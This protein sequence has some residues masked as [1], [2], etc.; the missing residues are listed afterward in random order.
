V[1]EAVLVY[2]VGTGGKVLWGHNV[3]IWQEVVES[4]VTQIHMGMS[5]CG[6]CFMLSIDFF[7]LLEFWVEMG[8]SGG[9]SQFNSFAN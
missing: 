7:M 8:D 4:E 3:L 2:Q 5:G 6:F 9:F 1:S